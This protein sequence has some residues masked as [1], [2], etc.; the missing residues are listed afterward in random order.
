M[1]LLSVL[2]KYT[3]ANKWT[4]IRVECASKHSWLNCQNAISKPLLRSKAMLQV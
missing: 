3:V 1:T 4:S 2:R